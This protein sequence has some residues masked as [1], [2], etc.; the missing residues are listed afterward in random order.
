VL[1]YESK[2]ENYHVIAFTGQSVYK[3]RDKILEMS[4]K[5]GEII[6]Y[7]NAKSKGFDCKA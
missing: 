2:W 7:E 4:P 6:K 5:I 1:R 3:N